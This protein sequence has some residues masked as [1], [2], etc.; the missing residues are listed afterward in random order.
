MI[1][2]PQV[3][4][5]LGAALCLF[6]LSVTL[7]LAGA[8][9]ARP[10][11]LDGLSELERVT[12]VQECQALSAAYTHFSDNTDA[13]R[14][15]ALFAED[16]IWVPP[17][18]AIQGREAIRMFVNEIA[19]K[20]KAGNFLQ[21]RVTSDLHVELTDRDHARGAAYMMVY[22]FGAKTSTD[23]STSLAPVLIA[24]VSDEYVRT[25]AGWKFKSRTITVVAH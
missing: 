18:G 22:R 2:L 11:N 1:R 7:P 19:A 23:A 16:G 20:Q 8:P 4:S 5:A 15:A 25:A 12:A 3:R 9:S 21:R 14:L 10:A 13:E 6:L 17:S 24:D